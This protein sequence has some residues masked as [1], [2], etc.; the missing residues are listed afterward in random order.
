M[1]TYFP[2]LLPKAIGNAKTVR[3]D[4]SSRFGKFIEIG[5]ASNQE[6][7]GAT[8][9][10]YLLEK[11]RVVNHSA[12][13]RNYHIFYQL[14]A[15]HDDDW[16]ADLQLGEQYFLHFTPHNLIGGF[17]DGHTTAYMMSL[18]SHPNCRACRESVEHVL[19]ECA[20]YDSQRLIFRTV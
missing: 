19:F 11:S 1:G 16:L 14:C 3:N 5:F 20:L 10:T 9:R 8:M 18:P 6:I 2:F 4:N 15:A 7:V 13:E 17:I 12:G